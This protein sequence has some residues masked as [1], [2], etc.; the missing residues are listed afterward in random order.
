MICPNC[1]KI[2]RPFIYTSSDHCQCSSFVYEHT[3]SLP[4]SA[5]D[6]LVLPHL[7]EPEEKP[8]EHRLTPDQIDAHMRSWAQT[9][10]HRK[11]AQEEKPLEWP[12]V[13]AQLDDFMT[14]LHGRDAND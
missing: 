6:H 13:E 8:P 1:Q 14:T 5:W 12:E 11:S 10:F 7:K 4:Y 3:F 2:I 9:F